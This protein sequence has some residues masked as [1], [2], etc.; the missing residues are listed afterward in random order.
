MRPLG[1]Q[2]AHDE[3]TGDGR[4]L[5]NALELAA[6]DLGDQGG[7]ALIPPLQAVPAR[8]DADDVDADEVDEW[9]EPG[10]VDGQGGAERPQHRTGG[11]PEDRIADAGQ[12]PHE[13]DLDVGDRLIPDVLALGALLLHGGGDAEDHRGDPRVGVVELQVALERGR[14]LSLVIGVELLDRG[15]EGQA[16]PDGLHTLEVV[17]AEQEGG[18]P[19]HAPQVLGG[20]RS[21]R[22]SGGIRFSS[23]S[24]ASFQLSR[25]RRPGRRP[26][27]RRHRHCSPLQRAAAIERA[28]GTRG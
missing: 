10:A 28:P 13:A 18:A 6:A 25:A 27:R 20:E 15:H 2:R 19:V 21:L 8:E 5:R 26:G 24:R 17:G 9:T 23:H 11:A 16:E 14:L 12:R 3:Q 22:S 4:D 1:D 7:A